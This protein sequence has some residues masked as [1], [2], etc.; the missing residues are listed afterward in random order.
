MEP[1]PTASHMNSD[2]SNYK[3][4]LNMQDWGT[5]EEVEGTT[6]LHPLFPYSPH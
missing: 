6:R 2:H 4:E 3:A 5:D 1:T